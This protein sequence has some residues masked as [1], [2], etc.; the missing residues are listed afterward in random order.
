MVLHCLVKR[1][2]TW[3]RNPWLMLALSV[4]LDK[5]QMFL[6][7]VSTICNKSKFLYSSP[8]LLKLFLLLSDLGNLSIWKYVK[9]W[10]GQPNGSRA[11]AEPGME[12]FSTIH[13]DLYFKSKVT[14][15]YSICVHANCLRFSLWILI[16][17]PLWSTK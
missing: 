3:F 11:V 14:S 2:K 12:T 7:S 4:K 17:L 6:G 13:L 1:W 15:G 8:D 9:F 16:M 10:E 5:S